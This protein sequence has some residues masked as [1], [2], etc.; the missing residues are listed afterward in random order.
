VTGSRQ[1]IRVVVDGAILRRPATGISRYVNGLWR[2]LLDQP[3]VSGALGAGPRRIERGGRLHRL[4]NLALERAWYERGI[5]DVARQAGADV[6]LMP[7]SI[8]A[9]RTEIPQVV[10]MHDVNFLTRPGTYER[11]FVRYA[12]W[13]YRRSARDADVLVAVSSFSR[14][15]I[16]RHL[17]VDPAPVRVI[18]PGLHPAPEGPFT[19]P[20]HERAYA[21]FVGATEV[22]K[23]VSLLIDAWAAS[24]PAGLDLAIVGQ[25]GRD[26]ESILA[27]AEGLGGRVIVTGR[28]D[29]EALERWYRHASVFV[30][31][32]RAEGFGYPPLEAMARGVPVIAARAAS[33][34]EVLGDAASYVDPDDPADLRR[35]VEELV[36]DIERREQ[37]IARGRERAA[38]Y[39]WSEAA[40]AMTAIL[41]MVAAGSRGG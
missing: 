12:T 7:A 2:S 11:G 38:R 24:S 28:A 15:E 29:D 41:R 19:K 13:A 10:T 22:H 14:D 25:P 34:P 36:D 33:L 31:P 6:L 21:L 8:G 37:R 4:P 26:H 17:D 16:A 27:R 18:Y 5:I 32:S 35:A 30:F 23:N 3:G 40:A 9:R 39:T 20:P 1:P